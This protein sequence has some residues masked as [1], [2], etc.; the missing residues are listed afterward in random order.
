[1]EKQLA[2]LEDDLAEILPTI[3]MALKT[4]KPTQENVVRIQR[5]PV[6][7]KTKKSSG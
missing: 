1:M 2:R 5:K 7:R 4:E 6:K 3:G